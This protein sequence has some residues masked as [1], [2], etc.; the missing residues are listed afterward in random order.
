MRCHSDDHKPILHKITCSNCKLIQD[1]SSKCI[2]PTCNI[3]FS[4]NYCLKCFIWTEVDIHHCDKCGLCRVGN[5]D[6]LFHCDN[7]D[8]CF[9][10]KNKE[11]HQCITKK[12]TNKV[13]LTYREQ[14]CAYC[15]DSTHNSQKSSL[16]L[17]CGHIVHHKCLSNA[18][19]SNQYRCPV[20]RQSINK[21]DWSYLKSLIDMQPMP[22]ED[23]N[24]GDTVTCIPFGNQFVKIIDIILFENS[25]IL[26]KGVIDNL[27]ISGSFNRE[28]LKKPLKKIEIYC[29]D[30]NN[31]SNTLF[32]YL[33][34]ECMNCGSFNT[35]K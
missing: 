31:K 3:S 22:E 5:K 16:L 10:I 15:F 11:E 23:I 27:N 34:N 26:Y 30:C 4:K 9:D 25:N 20:C 18:I 17:K 8:A 2:E 14:N 7:C 32:H 6:D 1:P 33:G 19:E 13:G 28:S 29:N 21:I 12:E 24:I 35:L